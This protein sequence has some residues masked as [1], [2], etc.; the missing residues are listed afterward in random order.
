MK[1]NSRQS[2][3]VFFC[4]GILLTLVVACQPQP[5]TAAEPEQVVVT[6]E[7]VVTQQVEVREEVEVTRQVQVEVTPTAAPDVEYPPVRIGLSSALSGPLAD[8]G[9]RYTKGMTMA[10]EDL[11]GEIMGRPLELYTADNKCNPT[12]AV[13]AIQQLIEVDEVHVILGSGCSGATLGSLPIILE[14]ETPQLTVA[15]SNPLIYDELG[16]GGNEWGFRINPDDQIMAQTFSPYIAE[17]AET[18]FTLAENTDFGRGAI[19]RY[20]VELP[21]AGVEVLGSEYFDLG[22]SDV[23]A[24]LTRVKS[25][26]PD[27]ILIVTTEQLGHVI[28]RQIREV[29][30]DAAI[31]S[32]GSLTTPLMLELTAD[33]PSI[34]EGVIEA[35][36]WA[37]GVDRPTEQ[38]FEERW[39]I[40]VS[41]HPMLAYYG[42]T[43]V[44]APAIECA[45]AETGDV[46]RTAIR[47]CLEQTSVDTPV[48]H[49]D[50]D[51]HNQSYINM[52]LSTITN[53]QTVLLDT[54]ASVPRD[55]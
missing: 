30:I 9:D 22:A 46:S 38:R 26:D 32:R 13:T 28:L 54:I 14:G 1:A 42:V 23:R 33:D 41:P 21:A 34:A 39:D 4:I 17:G 12:D 2:I 45:I 3:F 50:F 48:G 36:F 31:Y 53:G 55:E 44:L 5:Q 35:S 19:D 7:I 24:A 16:V 49:I 43:Y 52:T 51:D 40:S 47:D 20:L 18:V 8:L 15:S 11:G 25:L 27:A 29:G 6:R 37:G 10:I